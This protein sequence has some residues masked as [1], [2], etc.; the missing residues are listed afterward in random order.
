MKLKKPPLIFSKALFK[1]SEEDGTLSNTLSDLT[2][3][4]K[5]VNSEPQFRLFLQAKRISSLQKFEVLTRVFGKDF[6]SSIL[7]LISHLSGPESVKTLNEFSSFFEKLV[8]D[9]AISFM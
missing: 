2:L 5:T 7:E 8:K 9:T 3:L 6:N 1:L 4:K